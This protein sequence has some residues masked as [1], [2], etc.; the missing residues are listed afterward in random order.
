MTRLPSSRR[1]RAAAAS[2]DDRIAAERAPGE[3]R[4]S[5]SSW[6]AP[7]YSWRTEQVRHRE[8]AATIM[9]ELRALRNSGH[10]G[11]SSLHISLIYRKDCTAEPEQSLTGRRRLSI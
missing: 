6:P 4:K 11:M 7:S 5:P 9:S 10:H 3:R 1:P 8:I 2:P